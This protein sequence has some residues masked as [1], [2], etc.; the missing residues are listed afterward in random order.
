VTQYL[1]RRI[2]EQ[3]NCTIRASQTVCPISANEGFSNIWGEKKARC[4]MFLPIYAKRIPYLT[5]LLVKPF[6]S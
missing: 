4:P 2:Y 6:F 1:F 5:L 3:Q